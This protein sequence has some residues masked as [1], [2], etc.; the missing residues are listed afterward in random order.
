MS[1]ATAE[2]E[3]ILSLESI[4]WSGS[5]VHI[6]ITFNGVKFPSTFWYDFNLEE[7]HTHYGDEV[8]ERVYFYLALFS[9]LEL[10]SLKPT[11]IHISDKLAHHYTVQLQEIWKVCF[12]NGLGQWRYENGMAN[13]K[14]PQFS[15]QP[16]ATAPPPIKVKAPQVFVGDA[17]VDSIAYSSGGKDSLLCLKLLENAKVPFSSFSF[18][19]SPYGSA[20]DQYERAQKVLQ[21]CKPTRSHRVMITDSFLDIPLENDQWLENLQ[22]SSRNIAAFFPETLSIIPIMLQYGYQY[23]VIANERSANV[24]N[25]K[26]AAESGKAV[27]H[28]WIKSYESEQLLAK[29]LSQAFA[30]IHYYSI[31]QPIHDVVIFTL[32]RQHLHNLPFVYSCNVS[33]PWC[34]RCPKCCYVW[35][36]FQ[37]YMPQ[38]IIDPMFNNEN[39]LDVEENQLHFTQLLGLGELKPFECVGEISEV[40]LA[41]EL[42]RRKGLR[43]R[44]MEV[45]EREFG[46]TLD[47]SPI[48]KEYAVVHKENHSI[49]E[50]I[51]ELVIPIMEKATAS[52]KA[53][54]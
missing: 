3:R 35:L 38:H 32:L 13:W 11:I 41:F 25:L 24:G 16:Q 53:E 4:S 7:L 14:G 23:A 17:P 6:D 27:N 54:L 39:L 21:Q 36:S 47:V 44:A 48:L 15:C 9:L 19:S 20:R 46:Q 52:I 51:A 37:A 31:L 30:D 8:M 40:Q 28:Q 42:C 50:D 18:S 12:E 45:F 26:W 43:G 2:G 10:T 49:P 34:K 33:P 29:F 1:N 22:M 5:Q